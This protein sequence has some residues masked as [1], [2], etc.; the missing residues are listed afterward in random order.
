MFFSFEKNVGG[1]KMPNISVNSKN[2]FQMSNRDTWESAVF[3][4]DPEVL[5]DYIITPDKFKQL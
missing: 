4:A 2:G 5:E 1:I 3:F